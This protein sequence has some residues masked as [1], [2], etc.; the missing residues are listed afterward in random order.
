MHFGSHIAAVDRVEECARDDHVG[1][2]ED[3]Y[4][5]GGMAHRLVNHRRTPAPGDGRG[6]VAAV[7]IYD[8]RLDVDLRPGAQPFRGG[9][10]RVQRR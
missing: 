10:D 7:V 8:D 5:A 1:I 9:V 3:K 6:P 2:D 4:I